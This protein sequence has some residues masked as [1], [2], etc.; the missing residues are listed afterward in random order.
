[1]LERFLQGEVLGS[2]ALCCVAYIA[3]PSP[4]RVRRYFDLKAERYISEA[5]ATAFLGNDLSLLI[6]DYG[7]TWQPCPRATGR[8][9]SSRPI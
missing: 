2:I 3:E 1:M 5:I 8:R 4:P 6:A 9:S 7:S